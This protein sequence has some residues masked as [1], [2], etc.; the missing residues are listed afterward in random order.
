[1]LVGLTAAARPAAWADQVGEVDD[2]PPSA[3]ERPF[4]DWLLDP[5]ADEI[6]TVLRKVREHRLTLAGNSY[7]VHDHATGLWSGSNAELRQR[8]LA[9]L[10][11]MLRYGLRLSPRNIEVRGLHAIVLADAGDPGAEAALLGYLADELPERP[12]G[13]AR[14]RLAAIQARRGALAD[15]AAQLRLALASGFLEPSGGKEAVLALGQIYMHQGRLAEALDLLEPMAATGALP[16]SYPDLRMLL[17]LAVAYDRDE[18]LSQA[19][20]VFHRIGQ[21]GI[22]QLHNALADPHGSRVTFLM[23]TEKLYWSALQLEALGLLAEAKVEWSAYARVPGA[24]Y[25]ARA[26]AHARAIDHLLDQRAA[27]ARRT[28]RRPATPAPPAHAP[29]PIIP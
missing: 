29:N 9:D 13:D 22:E 5:H 3:I 2:A 17:A 23:P 19:H 16:Y 18:Q 25:A 21:L 7:P 15:A 14:L 26:R 8:L 24:R 10:A 6:D 20:E 27:E 11:G 12:T 28:H 1:V 4:W